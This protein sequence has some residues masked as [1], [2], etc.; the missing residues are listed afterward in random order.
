MCVSGS[1]VEERARRV[2]RWRE[3]GRR[4]VKVCGEAWSLVGA[5]SMSMA[6]CRTRVFNVRNGA[7]EPMK[8]KTVGGVVSKL[9][10]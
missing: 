5:S 7:R 4:V 10:G 2:R 9:V 1:V 8:V 3:G 6:N